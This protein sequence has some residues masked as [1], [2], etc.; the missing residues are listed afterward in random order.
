MLEDERP[1]GVIHVLVETEP[2]RDT[3]EQAGERS[4]AHRERFAPQVLA[5]KLD[6]VEGVEEDAR[7]VVPI[8]DAVKARDPVLSARHRLSVDEAGARAQLGERLNDQRKAVGEVIARS[9]VELHP[10]DFLPGDDA[11]AVVLDLVQPLLAGGRLRGRTGEAWRV[12]S[13]ADHPFL[14]SRDA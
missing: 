4:L 9:A 11:E 12:R 1:V 10:L 8:A 5:V 6:Q 2:R 7:V 14:A 3:G 13:L